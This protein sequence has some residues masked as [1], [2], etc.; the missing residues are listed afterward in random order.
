LESSGWGEF[1]IQA[2]LHRLNGQVDNLRHWIRFDGQNLDQG[3]RSEAIDKADGSLTTPDII[4]P[5]PTIFL[6]YLRQDAQLAGVLARTLKRRG[7]N[8]LLDV[9]IPSGVDLRRWIEEV[10][11][12][13]TAMV[14]LASDKTFPNFTAYTLG[15]ATSAGVR[16]IVVT[17]AELPADNPFAR[18]LSRYQQIQVKPGNPDNTAEY[19]AQRIIESLGEDGKHQAGSS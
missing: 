5:L 17:L 13:S 16:V 19:I 12:G 6:S 11:E 1:E 10:I 7:I 3:S 8:V 18:N 2:E 15:Y 14:V 9:D 4:H